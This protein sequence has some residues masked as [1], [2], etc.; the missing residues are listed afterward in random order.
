MLGEQ[1]HGVENGLHQDLHPIHLPLFL[2]RHLRGGL[3]LLL[4]CGLKLLLGVD[5]LIDDIQQ[6]PLGTF[7]NIEFAAG[8]R[9]GL[10]FLEIRIG[11]LEQCQSSL[12]ILSGSGLAECFRCFVCEF[13]PTTTCKFQL[14]GSRPLLLAFGKL[15]VVRFGRQVG[16]LFG[17]LLD[18]SGCFGC[19]IAISSDHPLAGSD[20][21]RYRLPTG[22]DHL[23]VGVSGIVHLLEVGLSHVSQVRLQSPH[24]LVVTF[25]LLGKRLFGRPTERRQM[26]ADLL[27][28]LLIRLRQRG[29]QLGIEVG[30]RANEDCDRPDQIVEGSTEQVGV[31]RDEL[32]MERHEAHCRRDAA[33]ND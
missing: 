2:A 8:L 15:R 1:L 4:L 7:L 31:G 33:Q 20:H 29:R 23:G 5:L 12:P 14:F 18:C 16:L 19:R 11:A 30:H 24:G 21:L 6:I 3:R 13:Q 9:F 25:L 17:G 10:R 22:L 27:R 32:G 26:L 28:K